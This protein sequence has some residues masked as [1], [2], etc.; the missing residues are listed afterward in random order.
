MAKTVNK[1]KNKTDR[2]VCENRM[3]IKLYQREMRFVFETL[4]NKQKK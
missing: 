3:I 4:K 2:N 1:N